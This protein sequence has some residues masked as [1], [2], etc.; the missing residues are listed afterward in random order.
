MHGQLPAGGCAVEIGAGT[1]RLALPLGIAIGIEP[2]F[3]MARIA[4]GRGLR[5]AAGIAEELP[6]PSSR[7]DFT[8]FVTTDCFLD[9][10]GAGFREAHRVLRTGGRVVVGFIDASG[11]LGKLYKETKREEPFY[12]L[13]TFHSANDLAALIAKAGF[14]GISFTQTLFDSLDEVDAVQASVP[15]HGEASFV[16]IRAAKS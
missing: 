13:A 1:G 7:F 4:R 12:R 14:G 8:L 6:L 5:V 16:V 15:G 3:E 10:V 9:D 11:P 2:S